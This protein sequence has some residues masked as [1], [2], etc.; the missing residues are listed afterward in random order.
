MTSQVCTLN[1]SVIAWMDLILALTCDNLHITKTTALS[2]I[3]ASRTVLFTSTHVCVQAYINNETLALEG[4][5]NPL[6]S[7]ATVEVRCNTAVC[8]FSICIANFSICALTWHLNMVCNLGCDQ[9]IVGLKSHTGRVMPS[10]PSGQG[11]WLL[12]YIQCFGLK[13]RQSK[14]GAVCAVLCSYM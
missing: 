13:L 4:G 5:V 11:V 8:S 7:F 14:S 3:I 2:F 10:W 12:P 6:D 9:G 1:A